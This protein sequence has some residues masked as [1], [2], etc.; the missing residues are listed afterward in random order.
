MTVIAIATLLCGVLVQPPARLTG[1]SG[2]WVLD[3]AKSALMD[4]SRRDVELTLVE[5]ENSIK[6][7]RRLKTSNP[8]I[9]GG[10]F[11]AETYTVATDGKPSEHRI[12]DLQYS[13]VLAREGRELVWRVTLKRGSDGAATT[14]T[15]RWSLSA[16]GNTLTI[17]TTYR[18][19]REV[20]QV[21][22]RKG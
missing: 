18:T 13:R 12:S 5:S 4:A 19:G 10:W 21:F 14:F 16:D 7:I 2:K 11:D 15:E 20:K 22:D 9:A 8:K 3:P 17:L 6:V 1:F